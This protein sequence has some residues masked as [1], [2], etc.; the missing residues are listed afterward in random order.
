MPEEIR[1]RGEKLGLRKGK[2]KKEGMRKKVAEEFGEEGI[3]SNSSRGR[4]S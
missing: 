1:N 2:L 4:E 3:E